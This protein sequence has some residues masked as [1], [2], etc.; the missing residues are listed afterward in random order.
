MPVSGGVTMG[1][2]KC[3][4]RADGRMRLRSTANENPLAGV[5]K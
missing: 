5:A 2:L 4:A 1:V 3:A